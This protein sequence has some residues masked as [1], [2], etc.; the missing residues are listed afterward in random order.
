MFL[1]FWLGIVAFFLVL[2][3]KER[4]QRT[5]VRHVS[6]KKKANEIR[7]KGRK[8]EKCNNAA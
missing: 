6:S 2:I 1:G 4:R 5:S 8:R 3:R 7:I